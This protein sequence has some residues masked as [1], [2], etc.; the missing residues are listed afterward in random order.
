MNNIKRPSAR[1]PVRRQS[2]SG[3]DQMPQNAKCPVAD[4]CLAIDLVLES[5]DGV[6]FGTHTKNLER[7][8]SNFPPLTPRNSEGPLDAVSLPESSDVV[9]LLLRSMH[10][11]RQPDSHSFTFDILSR[12]AEATE[13]YEVFPATEVCKIRMKEAIPD[14]P[15]PVLKY[16]VV[17]DYPELSDLAAPLTIELSLDTVKNGLQDR[18]DIFVAWVQYR[19]HWRENRF[20]GSLHVTL[21]RDLLVGMP[22]DME[23]QIKC[24]APMT[25]AIAD[26]V[27]KFSSFL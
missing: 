4:C 26:E 11:P 25:N 17:H 22:R 27:P 15:L 10:P 9:S 14:H 16:A 23:P 7:Y 6:R 20:R 2:A 1:V 18:L 3:S 21:E 12:L 24:G 8:S 19:E 5:S 13:K